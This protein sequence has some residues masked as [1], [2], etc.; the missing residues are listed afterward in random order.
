MDK[1]QALSML[2]I[3]AAPSC[4]QAIHVTCHKTG[5]H[6]EPGKVLPSQVDKVERP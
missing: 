6:A 1:Q 5:T 4:S 3:H 2:S